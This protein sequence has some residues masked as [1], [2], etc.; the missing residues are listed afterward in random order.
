MADAMWA[1]T[2]CILCECNC[3][4]EVQLEGRHLSRI[5]GDKAHPASQGY[6][7]N[8]AMRLDHYQNG[9]APADVARCGAA[10]TAAS[11]R[12]TGI[13]AIAEIAA[14]LHGDPRHLWRRDDPLLRRRRPGQPSRRRIQRRVPARA[15]VALP[16]E[17]AGAGEDGR[18]RGSTRISTA[19]TRGASSSMPR[20][21]CSSARTHGCRRASRAREVAARRWRKDPER[22]DDRDRPGSTDTAKLADFH[23]RVRPGTDAWCLAALAAVLV[24]EG[25]VDETFLPST[26]IGADDRS[27]RRCAEVTLREY[28]QHC[29]VD[30]ELIRAAA[31]RIAAADSVV[32]V[33]GPRHPAGAATARCAPT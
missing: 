5:R 13:T 23:L 32:G 4:I 30:E 10:P 21:R 25:L 27:S 3:G 8:K 20:W 24:Q 22:V 17:R 6:T 15:R 9:R 19:A 31:R 28:A 1:Q 33:R 14:S 11:R 7:C 29:G 18:V 16:V 2:A 12:S 26:C